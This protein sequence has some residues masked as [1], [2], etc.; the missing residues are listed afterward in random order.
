MSDNSRSIVAIGQHGVVASVNRQIAITEKLLTDLRKRMENLSTLPEDSRTFT[1][2][3]MGAK[4]VLIPAGTFMMGSPE[5]EQPFSPDDQTSHQVT[6]SKPFYLQTTP[7]TQR[8]WEVVMGN[9]PSQFKGKDRPVE[10]VSWGIVKRYIQKL[11]E[12]VGN[13]GYR[14]PTEAE[15]E[16]A[17]KSGMKEV[18]AGTSHES[19]LMDY[20]WYAANSGKK[21][22]PVGQKKPN[23]LGIYDMSGN[24]WEWCSDGYRD[25]YYFTRGGCYLNNQL[26]V[27]AASRG[28]CI[29]DAHAGTIGFR[30]AVS[31]D[32]RKQSNWLNRA[33]DLDDL[34]DWH[35]ML[36]W[37]TKWTKSEPEDA[38]A[39]SFLGL[40][41]GNLKY[42]DETINA[43]R[44]SLRID[45]DKVTVWVLLGE[46]YNRLKRYDE[47]IDAYHEALRIN[48]KKA[49]A[50]IGVGN[51]CYDLNLC[52]KAI[53]AYRKA[54]RI[55]PNK[56]N[57]WQGLVLAYRKLG[58]L[59]NAL[60][61]IRELRRRAPA[62]AD[63]LLDLIGP[64]K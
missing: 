55:D 43:Y 35:G 22:H 11:N 16:Y 7:V 46:A 14:L 30:I 15:W 44:E 50:W 53:Y 25:E 54:L 26:F 48:P 58:N 2:P 1:C 41:Y 60:D 52:D 40:A 62:K 33:C 34:G 47:S 17:A 20:A 27:R 38:D 19:S 32:G 6:I 18:W 13:N 21:T 9:N 39:W 42:N 64:R 4:F 63:K 31:P 36:D 57:A 56:I 28:A 12:L 23:S 59:T 49:I 61:A 8:Q 10:N 24:V 45:P 51:T 37:C 29:P 3:I 5:D